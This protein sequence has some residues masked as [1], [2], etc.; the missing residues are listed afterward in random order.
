VSDG[1]DPAAFRTMMARWATGVAVVTAR[2]GA[3]EVGLTVNAFLSVSLFPPSVLVSLKD[4]VDSLPP[5]ERSR[6]FAVNVLAADQRAVSER[7]ARAV[8]WAEKFRDLPFHRGTTGAALLDGT[9]GAVECRLLAVTPAFDHRLV[10]GEVVR[11]EPGRDGPPLLFFRS[12]YSAADAD[13]RLSFPGARSPP[14]PG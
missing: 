9:L 13:G 3:T 12:G 8:P 2:D 10:L 11:V 14:G 5:I 4:D 1:P 7:F 6:A